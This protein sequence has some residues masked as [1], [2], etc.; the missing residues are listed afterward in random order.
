MQRTRL[1]LVTLCLL[2]VMG[3]RAQRNVYI[4]EEV[5]GC[6]RVRI[7]N[8]VDRIA[9][10]Q[11]ST[12]VWSGGRVTGI[13]F[14]TPTVGMMS[15]REKDPWRAKVMPERYLADFDY[16]IAFE[17]A[18]K[19]RVK[20]EPVT[21]DEASVQYDDF[22]EHSTWTKTVYINYD[23]MDVTVEGDTDS[24]TVTCECAH[25]TIETAAAGVRYIISGTSSDA[26]FKLYSGRK[27]CLVLNGTDL[28]NPYGP[29]INSQLKKRLFIEIAENTVNKL[30]DG[31]AYIK[32]KGED[33]R[34]CIFAEGKICISGG[35]QLYVTG[36]KKCGIASDEYVHIIGGFIHVAA[37][38]H[39]GKAVYGQENVIIGGGV[40]RTLSDGAAGKGVASD[41]L[42]W[43]TGGVIK[44]VTTGDAVW[45]EE[46]EDYS[47][48]CAIKS[49]WDMN[50]TGGEIYCL[51]TGDG[52]KGI[53]A[54]T[55]T[56][57]N[58]KTVYNG[59]LTIA[60][61]DIRV[62]TTG[63]RIPL[64]KQEDGHGHKI[65][66]SASPKCIKSIGKLTVHSGDIR[67]RG[68]G[69][70]AAEGLESKRQAEINGGTI[71]AY[72]VDDGLNSTGGTINGGDILLCS[73]ENDGFDASYLKV[74]G[75]RLY[76]V[77]G[78][79]GQMGIDTDGKTFELKGG[80]VVGV[81]ALSCHPHGTS[82]QGSIIAYLNKRNVSG[83]ALAD[84]NGNT[85]TAVPTPSEYTTLCV[86]FSSEDITVGNSYK[87]LSYKDTFLD[88]P[89]TEYEFTLESEYIMLGRKK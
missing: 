56:E 45:E 2:S 52:G 79:A 83:V 27:A 19:G 21:T 29:V 88:T 59:T 44:A 57:V 68:S 72:C 7:V 26:F 85:I 51:S 3:G 69:G 82:T 18:D 33:Q 60:G 74:N 1:I 34:G 73:S 65:G 64:E 22:V 55:Q 17:E 6:N 67:V 63:T 70:M 66:A 78:A 53:A 58:G 46:E 16:D 37:H 54:G 84:A 89:V 38:A 8:D 30:T 71:R 62:R 75:G 61:A 47:S 80:E 50:I 28:T 36:K 24:L 35:G 12:T 13:S 77:G 15:F 48:S 5:N 39:K 11:D 4:N 43:I 23:D 10:G 81:G 31:D 9:F 20:A 41:S 76:A 32:V 87:I 40:L 86:F 49:A 25:L 14:A 42:L